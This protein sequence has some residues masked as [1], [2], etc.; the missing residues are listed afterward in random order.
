MIGHSS[1]KCIE[2]RDN[3]LIHE[4]LYSRP[5]YKYSLLNALMYMHHCAVMLYSTQH[6]A[7]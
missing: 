1:L 5:M 2:I 3:T 4:H 7:F 6:L